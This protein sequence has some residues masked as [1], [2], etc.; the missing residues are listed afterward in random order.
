MD[1]KAFH[2]VVEKV[3]AVL[4]ESG[5]QPAADSPREKDG[6]SA[7]FIG[8]QSA[9]SILYRENRKRFELRTCGL[10]DGKPDGKWDSVSMW[11]YDPETDSI[12]QVQ[13]IIEDFNETIVGPQ[14]INAVVRTKKKKRKDDDNNVDPQFFFNRFVSVFPELKDEIT[15]EK[16]AYS[17]IRAVSFARSHLLPRLEALFSA[18]AE[19]DLIT[20]TCGLL[21]S[22][23]VSGDMDV[24]SV[25]TIV[26]L[27]GLSDRAIEVIKPLFSEELAKGYKA[28]LKMKGKKVK[29]EK[30][31]KSQSIMAATLNEMERQNEK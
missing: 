10:E 18:G 28:G 17:G 4:Q 3:G 20:K 19:K 22:M 13:S 1:Q 14:Q 8:S 16:A 15:A 7:L 12:E 9:Y 30:R 11:L 6:Q 2:L 5:F 21:S 27:N 25:I 24:R 29:P 31:K 23:Y 26:L